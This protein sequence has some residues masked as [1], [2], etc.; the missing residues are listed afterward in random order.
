TAI[1]THSPGP[2]TSVA[3]T[4]P[5]IEAMAGTDRSMPPGS[6]VIVSQAARMA[7]GM[8]VR[9]ITPAQLRLTMPGRMISLR[10]TSR[11]RITSKGMIGRSRNTFTHADGRNQEVRASGVVSAT[12]IGGS[13]ATG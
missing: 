11:T 5:D 9:T 12:V 7:S 2:L 10:I 3:T 4:N 8:A 6:I 13:S 1:P